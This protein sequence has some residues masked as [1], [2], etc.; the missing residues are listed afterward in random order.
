MPVAD[1]NPSVRRNCYA[2][3]MGADGHVSIESDESRVQSPSDRD[4]DRIRCTKVDVETAQNPS[5]CIDI[6]GCDLRPVC[7]SSEPRIEIRECELPVF[8]REARVRTPR[9]QT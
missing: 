9:R 7:R 3:S 4:V 2:E 8:P 5:C 6:G 1:S